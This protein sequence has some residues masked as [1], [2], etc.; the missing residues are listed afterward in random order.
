MINKVN[1]QGDFEVV[2][3]GRVC[4]TAKIVIAVLLDYAAAAAPLC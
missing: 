1:Q 4:V 3:T 2:C